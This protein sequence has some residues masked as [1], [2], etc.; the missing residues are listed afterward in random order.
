MR[1]AEKPK[2]LPPATDEWRP[3]S[4]R[5]DKP[6]GVLV[7][8]GPSL[9]G[10]KMLSWKQWYPTERARQDAIAAIGRKRFYKSRYTA[11]PINA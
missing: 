2:P 9:L 3:Q 7:T 6:F 5:K 1:D 8:Y 10:G 4:K 11:E